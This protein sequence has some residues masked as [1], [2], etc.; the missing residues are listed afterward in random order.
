MMK[1]E[2]DRMEVNLIEAKLMAVRLEMMRLGR[3]F[4]NCLSLKICLS[5]K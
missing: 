3:K 2:L 5:P 4:K 1:V